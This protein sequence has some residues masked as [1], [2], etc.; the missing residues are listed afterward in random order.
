MENMDRHY[1]IGGR[2]WKDFVRF[3]AMFVKIFNIPLL[4]ITD[5]PHSGAFENDKLGIPW[6]FSAAAFA[7]SLM[8]MLWCLAETTRMEIISGL[9]IFVTLSLCYLGASVTVVCYVALDA[10]ALHENVAAFAGFVTVLA[11][12]IALDLYLYRSLVLK[13][14][15]LGRK[16]RENVK[17][18]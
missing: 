10:K 12:A 9:I 16:M 17:T 11:V 1:F 6:I 13:Y 18:S 14:R 4:Y 15:S 2:S 7:S 3:A 5:L 8:Y